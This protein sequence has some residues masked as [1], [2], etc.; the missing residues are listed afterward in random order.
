MELPETTFA[1]VIALFR[2]LCMHELPMRAVYRWKDRLTAQASE[3]CG[4]VE[5]SLEIADHLHHRVE[6]RNIAEEH[7]A[8]HGLEI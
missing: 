1:P 2:Q 8:E 3:S 6:V 7:G 4:R 5:G